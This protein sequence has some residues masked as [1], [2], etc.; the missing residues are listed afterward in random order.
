MYYL[1]FN[2]QKF[3]LPN[4]LVHWLYSRKAT[5]VSVT[6]GSEVLKSEQKKLQLF[7]DALQSHKALG[8]HVTGRNLSIRKLVLPA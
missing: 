1:Q 3:Y 2:Q 8:S 4:F 5:E 7:M 6:L